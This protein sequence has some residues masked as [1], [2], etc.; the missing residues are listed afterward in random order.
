MNR[1]IDAETRP[2]ARMKMQSGRAKMQCQVQA[3]SDK[4]D[5]VWSIAMMRGEVVANANIKPVKLSVEP[6]TKQKQKH[7]GAGGEE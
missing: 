2:S 5:T 3:D 7:P 1:A 6:G 4:V